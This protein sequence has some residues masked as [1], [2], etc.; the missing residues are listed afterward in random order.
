MNISISSYTNRK[1]HAHNDMHSI[2]MYHGHIIQQPC[3]PKISSKLSA[4]SMACHY[5][6]LVVEN[7]LIVVTIFCFWVI[8]TYGIH[9]PR[10]HT[11]HYNT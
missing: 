1:C 4:N 5:L 6:G 2:Y 8:P 3:I 7:T 10:T 11:S 9:I